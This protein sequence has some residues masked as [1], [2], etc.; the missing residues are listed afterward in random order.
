MFVSAE[1]FHTTI[2]CPKGVFSVQQMVQFLVIGLMIYDS[3]L[4]DMI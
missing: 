1:F 4:Y 2:L 3:I